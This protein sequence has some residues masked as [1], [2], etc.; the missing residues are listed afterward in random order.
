MPPAEV[1][2]PRLE[3][4]LG[5]P[6]GLQRGLAKAHTLCPGLCGVRQGFL[7]VTWLGVCVSMWLLLRAVGRE[8]CQAFP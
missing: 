5:P 2:C 8:Q 4:E 1:Q 3:A 6:R 7:Q